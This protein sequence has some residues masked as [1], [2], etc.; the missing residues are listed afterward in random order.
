MVFK[1]RTNSMIIE[2][3]AHLGICTV[4]DL[5]VSEEQL[6][7]TMDKNGIAAAV[8]QPFP[9]APNPM[10]VHDRIAALSQKYPGRIYGLASL[11]PHRDTG[12][13]EGEVTRCVRELGFVAIKIHTIGHAVNPLG[14]IADMVF[15]TA[16]RLSV[17][18][19]IHTGSGVPFSLPSHIVS[20]AQR[21][22][23]VK[24]I[25][26]HAGYGLFSPEAIITAQVC[27]NVYLEPSWCPP[28]S[29][30]GMIRTLGPDRVLFGSDMPIN[31]GPELAKYR[32]I[33][34]SDGEMEAAMWR[35]AARVYGIKAG[36]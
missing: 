28:G 1:D 35:T 33:G 34:L 25:M 9:G 11:S 4:F 13:Y 23:D 12:E 22:P 14:K 29:I 36:Q 19:M 21:Y 32:E 2:G 3:H 7:A 18:V 20:G 26:A 15:R 24:I 10:Q 27:P 16:R 5:E 30:L 17:P 8:V 31:Q 6:I